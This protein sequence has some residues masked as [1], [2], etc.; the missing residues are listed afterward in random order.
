MKRI[1]LIVLPAATP[2]SVTVTL[3]MFGIAARYP[4][5]A[6]CVLDVLSLAGGGV[7]L[8]ARI[9]IETAPMPDRLDGYDAVIIPG[10]FAADLAALIEQLTTGWR[11]LIERLA[12]V[13]P[14]AILA[15]SCY[16]TFVLAESGWLDQLRATT[17]W[18]L[19]AAFQMRYPRIRCAADQALVDDGRCVT[20]GAM[21]A[22]ADLSLQVLRRLFGTAL[23]RRVAGIMLID[24]G[25]TSQQPFMV[26]RRQ[27]DDP[28][29]QKAA[30]WL[31]QHG[32]SAVSAQALAAA[33]QVSY[34]TLHRRFQ[35][36]AGMPPLTYLQDLRVERAK[37]LLEGSRL[38]LEQIVEQV[39]YSDPPAFRRLFVRRV[40][41][42][43]ARYR[44]NFG[45]A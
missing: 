39:G 22:H 34:R 10:F 25:R 31:A 30:D 3:D 20:A 15:A 28:L 36:A 11:P 17:T 24:G 7:A 18:W 27:F 33:L 29:V 6:D 9:G 40:G 19:Q 44:R 45:R 16:G 23:A 2:S 43:P 5:A 26:V 8:S 37:E 35:A 12:T 13:S 14:Q 42:S 21:T 41:L 1:A 38:S 32:A 4:E